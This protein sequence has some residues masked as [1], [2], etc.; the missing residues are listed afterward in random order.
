MITTEEYSSMVDESSAMVGVV[1]EKPPG[2]T[3]YKGHENGLDIGLDDGV[4]EVFLAD[5]DDGVGGQVSDEEGMLH[6]RGGR[7]VVRD[8]AADARHGVSK[9]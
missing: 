3:L 7:T 2:S 8:A 9:A 5:A 4:S 1:A 6:Q